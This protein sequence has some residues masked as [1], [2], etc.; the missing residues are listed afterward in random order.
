MIVTRRCSG[1]SYAQYWSGNYYWSWSWSNHYPCSYPWSG[2]TVSKSM[3]WYW[4][5]CIS[6][7]FWKKD[8]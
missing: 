7:R 2:S 4:S 1:F 8:I 3:C 5:D 6:F